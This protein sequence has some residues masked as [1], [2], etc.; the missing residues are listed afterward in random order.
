M[1][2]SRERLGGVGLL[3][4]ALDPA[5]GVVDH[6]AVL[7][8]V[9]DLLDGQRG[10]PAR[11]AV[12]LHQR[13]Q[14]DVGER[15]A[16]DD[17]DRVVAEEVGH[18]AHTAGRAQQLLLEAV[19][20]AVAEVGADRVRVVVEVGDQLGRSPGAASSPTM[21]AITGRSSTGTIGFGISKV[22]GFSRVPSPAAST[23]AFIAARTLVHRRRHRDGSGYADA[24]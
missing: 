2:R 19:L 3:L 14:V 12:A 4:E 24:A 18:V 7:A 11:A 16:R 10:D 20:E 9:G 6:H 21:C 15:V 8:R 17:H 1:P 5:V 22:I 23:I 13:A